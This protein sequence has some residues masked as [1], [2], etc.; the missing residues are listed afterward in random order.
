[1]SVNN[2]EAIVLQANIYISNINRLL[3]DVKSKVSANFIYSNNKDIIT[4][5]NKTVASLDLSIV[6]RYVKEL[7]NINSN[8]SMSL[9]LPQ[10]KSYLKILEVLYFLENMNLPIT[11]NIIEEVIKDTYIFNDIILASCPYVIKAS[12]KSDMAV[13]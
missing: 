9:Q 7:N 3:K 1:M 10:S 2:S 8:D 4:T 6:E 12:S 11:S 5:T 13:I